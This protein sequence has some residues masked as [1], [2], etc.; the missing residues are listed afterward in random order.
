MSKSSSVRF[1]SATSAFIAGADLTGKENTFVKLDTSNEGK[2]LSSGA[3]EEVEG[4]LMTSDAT[5]DK[6]AEVAVT[7]YE[8]V[9]AGAT[10]AVGDYVKSDANGKAITAVSTDL[11]VAKAITGGVVD[12]LIEVSLFNRKVI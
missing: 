11:G 6:P 5:L 7:G 10:V 1:K 9:L 4:I 12:T 8:L 2:V 3:G